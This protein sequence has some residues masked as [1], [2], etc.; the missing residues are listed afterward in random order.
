ML[1]HNVP[2]GSRQPDPERLRALKAYPVSGNYKALRRLLVSF[3]YNA[4]WV[5]QYSSKIQTLLAA[6]KQGDFL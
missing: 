4:K 6:Q 1:G 5:A 2:A 3:A